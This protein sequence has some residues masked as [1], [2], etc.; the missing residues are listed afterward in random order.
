MGRL[1]VGW[2]LGWM[3]GSDQVGGQ[4]GGG[5]SKFSRFGV[6]SE[7]FEAAKVV[8]HDGVEHVL[9]LHRGCASHSWPHLGAVSGPVLAWVWEVLLVVQVMQR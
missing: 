6:A 1:V 5:H 8:G 3:G 7:F 2:M 4:L 9:D